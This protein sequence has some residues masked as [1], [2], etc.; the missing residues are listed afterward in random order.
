MPLPVNTKQA[1]IRCSKCGKSGEFRPGHRQCRSCERAS[2]LERKRA[3]PERAAAY[4]EANRERYRRLNVEIL[5]RR[6][7]ELH[8]KIDGVKS[9]SCT[10][11]GEVYPPYVMDFDHRDP[12]TKKYEIS[13]IVNKSSAP[14]ARILREI[15]KCDVVCVNC[16]R[17]RTWTPPKQMGS[18]QRLVTRLKDRPCADCGKKLHYCQMD[19]DHVRGEKLGCVPHMGSTAAI[20]AEA[21]K[22]DVVCANCH[23][24][25][26]HKSA[27]G[28]SR[29][30][31]ATIDM[32]W[33]RRSSKTPQTLVKPR[34]DPVP[35]ELKE[36]EP[37][38]R[39]WHVLAGKFPDREVARIGDV[40]P[41]MVCL[42]RKRMRIPPYRSSSLAS[43]PWHDMVGTMTDSELSR[44]TGVSRK[45]IQRHRKDFGLPT[46]PRGHEAHG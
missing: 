17:L 12:T 22:C 36:G 23:R 43:A 8:A 19:F 45:T 31:P 32:T 20:T 14:W 5:R 44:Q 16:H 30:D 41:V 25:R 11:C 9:Q 38:P 4:R 33:Q 24:I 3:N 18:K 1:P 6:K 2:D 28:A 34:P 37:A 40:S 39:P 7:S 26:S 46:S 21:A 13:Q 10:D 15:K 42:Y 35:Y 29:N 27:K